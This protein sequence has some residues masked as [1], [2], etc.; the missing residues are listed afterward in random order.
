MPLEGK[1]SSHYGWRRDP[2]TEEP[3]FHKG[4]DLAAPRGTP[5]LSSAEGTVVFSGWQGGYGN[6]VVIR[7]PDGYETRYAHNAQN[8]VHEGEHVGQGDMIARVGS[9]GRST[10][11]HLHFEVTK[12]GKAVDPADLLA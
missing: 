7:H 2:F 4:V 12:G 3:R 11:P 5:V 10:G 6:T 1:V 9:T 8:L